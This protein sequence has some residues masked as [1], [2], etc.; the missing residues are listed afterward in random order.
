MPALRSRVARQPPL[1]PAYAY[2]TLA[3]VANGCRVSSRRE[4]RTAT[5]APSDLLAPQGQL[6]TLR[7]P[8]R[9]LALLI[10]RGSAGL[11]RVSPS[12]YGASAVR[13]TG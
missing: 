4:P 8:M 10:V 12:M 2:R 11:A 6:T 5:A 9:W 13:S 3:K 1:R 7:P